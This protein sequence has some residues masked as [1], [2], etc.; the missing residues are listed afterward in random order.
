MSG[1]AAAAIPAASA[2]IVPHTRSGR[3]PSLSDRIPIPNCPMAMPTRN[4]VMVS[5]TVDAPTP[6]SFA[7]AVNAGRYISVAR[8]VTAAS[9]ARDR[10]SEAGNNRWKA[11]FS[12]VC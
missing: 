6:M 10:R 7:I 11:V 8:G 12:N 5:C 3:R 2:R 4:A 1:A 9:A